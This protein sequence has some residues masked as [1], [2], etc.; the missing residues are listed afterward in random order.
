MSDSTTK[1]NRDGDRCRLPPHHRRD[2]GFTL[3]E[4]L[5]VVTIFG[6]LAMTAAPSF[7]ALIAS[8]RAEAAATELYVSLVT[9]RSEATKR[10][11][12][13][14]LQQKSG[15]WQMGW[16][17]SVVDPGDGSSTLTIEDHPVTN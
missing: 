15:G 5:T 2:A 12:D 9:S 16:L 3:I 7:A 8:K 6:I 1:L 13:A 11:A 4:L 17:L 10:N 14:T